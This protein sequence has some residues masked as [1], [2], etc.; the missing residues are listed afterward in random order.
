MDI[1]IEQ[2]IDVLVEAIYSFRPGAHVASS[3]NG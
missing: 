1:A 3:V 2:L